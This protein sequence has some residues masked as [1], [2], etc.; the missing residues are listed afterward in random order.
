MRSR[1]WLLRILAVTGLGVLAGPLHDSVAV[2]PKVRSQWMPQ[3]SAMGAISRG[4]VPPPVVT[5]PP[6]GAR[7]SAPA[8]PAAPAGVQGIDRLVHD[9]NAPDFQSETTIAVHGSHVLVGYNDIRGF[10]ESSVSVSGI[11]TSSDG[12]VTW[13][14]RGRLPTLGT[15]DAIMGDPDVEAWTD[16]SG[17]TLYFYSSLYTTPDGGKSIC[18]QVSSDDGV[19]WSPPREVTSATTSVDFPDKSF[20]DVDRET[21]R[22][23]VSWTNFGTP[24]ITIRIA[25]SDDFGLTWSPPTIFAS[26][27]S[28]TVPRADGG[29]DNVYLLW[30]EADKLLFARSEDNGATWASPTTLAEGLGDPMNPYGSDRINGFPSMDVDDT[31]GNVY[32]VC[33][34]RNS[35]PDFCDI[36]FLRS[37][38]GGVTFSSPVAVNARPGQDRCQFFPWIC[39]DQSDGALSVTWLDQMF[40]TGTS[41]TTD[42]FHTH[43]TDAGATW[44]C[45]GPLTD[46]RFHAEAGNST[47]QPN[48]GDYNQCAAQDGLLY[49]AFAK[50][51][52]PSI[53]TYSPDVYV[54]V[55]PIAGPD[56]APVTL[57]GMTFS[58]RGCSSGNGYWEP[59]ETVDLN[60]TL[61]NYGTCRSAISGLSGTL[62]ALDPGV[63]ILAADRAFPSLGGPGTTSTNT[64]PF[65]V[66]LDRGLDCGPE[67]NF[68]LEVSSSAGPVSIPFRHRIGRPVRTPILSEDFD[69]VTAPSLPAGWTSKGLG[70]TVNPWKTSTLFAASGT[71]ALYCADIATTG[72]NEVWSPAFTLPAGTGLL[73]V[74]FVVTQN[75]EYENERRAW[76]GALLRVRVDGRPYLA[77]AIATRFE[78]FYPWQM[79]RQ[80]STRQPFQDLACWSG[81]TTPDF[82]P[83]RL[84]FPDLGGHS[85]Q[86]AFDM[87]TDGSV[88]T[89]TGMFVDNLVINRIDFDC[90]CTDPPSLAW[91][92]GQ[93]VFT[94]IPAFKTSCDTVTILNRGPNPLVID[95]VTGCSPTPFDLD[96]SGLD[97]TV[98]GGDST[99]LVVCAT[100]TEA[101]PDTCFITVTSNDPTSPASIP[102]VVA[103]VTGVPGRAFEVFFPAPSPFRDR[104]RIGF[105]LPRAMPV[106][107]DVWSVTGRRVRVLLDHEMKEAGLQD[108]YWNGDDEA[109]RRVAAGL[110]F[111]RVATPAGVRSVRVVRL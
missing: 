76:D 95:G 104:T 97:S 32:V 31:S 34:A 60:L 94:S 23:F 111:V 10:S 98:A 12:G 70:G 49:A 82:S 92:P 109:G 38:D 57:A 24:D 72:L 48:L 16:G 71:N 47:S 105:N 53:L 29:S 4:D 39:V 93:V 44:T 8:S 56:A 66:R 87:S 2:D 101:G 35:P 68:R 9:P 74:A 50:T 11:S 20:I 65:T 13:T 27:G 14:D 100:P 96:L 26:Y 63:E 79:N 55:S 28:G 102:V 41:D 36:L 84:E 106:T 108:L 69:G 17:Q 110:Y 58:D 78:P 77:G 25:H 75:I 43:S 81:N 83:V 3:I 88:G 54:D 90:G 86:L 85:V 22:L 103:S 73:E 33:P 89:P 1:R 40:G 91:A 7:P 59:S 62:V 99:R 52:L 21:G 61:R 5:P 46:D 80:P 19:T 45:P 6:F 18:V 64:L 67:V 51:D 37:T 30:R 42:V 15:G 107:A